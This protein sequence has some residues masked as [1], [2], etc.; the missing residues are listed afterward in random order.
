ME[1]ERIKI[2]K[3]TSVGLLNWRPGKPL[4]VF[5]IMEYAEVECF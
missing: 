5:G 4:R 3:T 2:D 1:K